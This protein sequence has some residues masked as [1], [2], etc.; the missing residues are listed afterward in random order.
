MQQQLSRCRSTTSCSR[1]AQGLL[2]PPLQRLQRN[3]LLRINAQVASSATT[4]SSTQQVADTD[5]QIAKRELLSWLS[6]TRRG[7]NTTKLL[8][9]QIE[10]AQV[11]CS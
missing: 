1:Q 2:H 8:R 3:H 9:G 4:L 7:S 6:G 10:E 5:K 11:E